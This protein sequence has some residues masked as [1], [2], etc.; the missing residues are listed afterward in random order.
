MPNFTSR[1]SATAG[2]YDWLGAELEASFAAP[3]PYEA[4][5][6]VVRR[7][8]PEQLDRFR[9]G[10]SVLVPAWKLDGHSAQAAGF[11]DV[12]PQDREMRAAEYEVG[13]DD[14]TTPTGRSAT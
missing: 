14:R 2:L 8:V 12:V 3:H 6:V 4:F 7:A 13:P 10:L 1:T 9:R 11:V 5:G